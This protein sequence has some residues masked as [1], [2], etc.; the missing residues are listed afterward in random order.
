MTYIPKHLQ[1]AFRFTDK[2]L[3]NPDI[4]KALNRNAGI[5]EF[6]VF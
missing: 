6:R 5:A 1:E 2:M 3:K 4:A